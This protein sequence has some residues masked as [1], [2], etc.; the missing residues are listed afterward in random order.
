ML[1]KV[2]AVQSRMGQ[3]LSLSEKIHIFKE[4][5][6][7][8]CL[9]EYSLM[10]RSI[11]DYHRAALLYREHLDYLIGLSEELRTCLIAGTVVEPEDDRLYNACYV[12]NRGL[13]LGRYRKRYPVEGERRKGIAPGDRN[14]VVEVNGVRVGLMICGDV[15]FPHLYGELGEEQADV[16]FVP[17][18]SAYRPEDTVSRK[19]DRDNTYFQSGSGAAG[20]YVVKVCS[21]GRIFDMEL[22]GRSLIAAPWGML[23]RVDFTAES[24]PRILSEILDIA[25]LREFRCKLKRRSEVKSLPGE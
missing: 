22:H 23:R 21:V 2:V 14:L 19:K 8:V 3:K 6:D 24:N 1:I 16:I 25:E 9:P 10:D 4:R 11:T 17:T 13:V 20:A 5:P 12:I 7:F 18:T 15:F